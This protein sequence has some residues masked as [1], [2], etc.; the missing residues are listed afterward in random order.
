MFCDENDHIHMSVRS[1][2][3]I[4]FAYIHSIITYGITLG[5]TRH[6]PQIILEFKK[7]N[8]NYDESEEKA[9]M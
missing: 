4:Y 6:I 5:V 1:L 2:R 7:G 3:M 9:F 8:K